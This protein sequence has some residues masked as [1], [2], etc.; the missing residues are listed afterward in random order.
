MVR[1]T[2][3]RQALSSLPPSN[4]QS[5]HPRT[6][7]PFLYQT[8][9]IQQRAAKRPQA[10]RRANLH[11]GF[12]SKARID[13]PVPFDDG[14]VTEDRQRTSTITDVE[15]Q[16]FARLFN[17]AVSGSTQKPASRKKDAPQGEDREPEGLDRILAKVVS[18]VKSKPR[19]RPVTEGEDFVRRF[20]PSL[21]QMA[22]SAKENIERE[23]H[24]MAIEHQVTETGPQADP[25]RQVR[26]KEAQRVEGLLRAAKTDMELWIVLENEVFSVIRQL[27]LEQRFETGEARQPNSKRGKPKKKKKN[28]DAEEYTSPGTRSTAQTPAQEPSKQEGIPDIRVIGPN[29]P[30]FLLL[31][32]RQ[33]RQEF[34]SSLLTFSLLP[35]VKKL[36]RASYALGA[37][38]LFYNELIGATWHTYADFQGVGELLQEMDNGGIDFDT[39]TLDLLHSIKKQWFQVQRG[40]FG[41]NLAAVWGL[42]SMQRGLW[43]VQRWQHVIRER[44]EAEAL[45]LANEREVLANER[46]MDVESRIGY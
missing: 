29:Y 42:E 7:L 2:I 33:L 41:D 6:L 20:P 17:M 37:S 23:E 26:E 4:C 36:G 3:A 11:S 9:T 19:A 15:R 46:E 12:V 44:M 38:T 40:R 18:D 24:E 43:K 31:A 27:G 28:E 5:V 35:A 30:S 10:W 13:E 34:P 16:T 25:V 8:C 21:R 39:S 1:S 14:M 32:I 45:R 22:A